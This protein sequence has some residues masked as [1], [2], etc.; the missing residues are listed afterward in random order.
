MDRRLQPR[1]ERMESMVTGYSH[2]LVGTEPRARMG[3]RTLFLSGVR[4][5][6]QA[7]CGLKGHDLIRHYERERVALACASCGHVSPGWTV[8]EAKPQLRYAGDPRRHQL[9]RPQAVRRVA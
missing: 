5:V 1:I 4:R 7:L 8:A 9:Q 3:V 2:V 6:G